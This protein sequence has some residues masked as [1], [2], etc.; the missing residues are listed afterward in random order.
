MQTES[1]GGLRVEWKQ[2]VEV[3]HRD[4]TIVKARHVATVFF[5]GDFL[6][7]LT[8]LTGRFTP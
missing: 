4:H 3:G 7:F 2:T 6:T 5:P 1:S 8:F